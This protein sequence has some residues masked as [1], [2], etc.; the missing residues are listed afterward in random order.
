MAK[1]PHILIAGMLTSL[2]V[3]L[4][5]APSSALPAGS[6]SSLGNHNRKTVLDAQSV[7][8]SEHLSG[9][10]SSKSTN[11][12]SG[13]ESLI[14]NE[15]NVL[16]D[17]QSYDAKKKI[18][19]AQGNV[20]LKINSALLNADRVEFNTKLRRIY[21][22]GNVRFKSG[23]QYF[24]A[25][26]FRYN[27]D[28]KIGQLSDVYGVV[29]VDSINKDLKILSKTTKIKLNNQPVS[30]SGGYFVRKDSN[31]SLLNK[32]S[33]SSEF[34][35]R[36]TTSTDS[37]NLFRPNLR[38]KL[39]KIACPPELPPLIPR[40]TKPWSITTWGGVMTDSP[41]GESVYLKSKVRDEYLFGLGINKRIYKTGPL[42]FE[43]E[44]DLLSH[45]AQKQPGGKHQKVRFA[46]TG[47]QSF[48]ELIIG[49]GTRVW[50]KPWLNIAFIEGLSFNSSMSNW[51]KTN[52]KNHS[53]LLNYL[54]FE[55]E[56]LVSE[57]LSLVGRIHHRSGAFGTF[58][59]VK[60]GSNA[61]LVGFKYRFGLNKKN[62]YSLK[63]NPPLDCNYPSGN[64]RKWPTTFD[65]SLEILSLSS[66]EKDYSS[67]GENKYLE[68]ISQTKLSVLSISE[69]IKLRK[70]LISKLDQRINSI[71]YID[72]FLI[73]GQ[74]GL[75][76][77]FRNIDEKTNRSSIK[78][79]QLEGLRRAKLIT[80]SIKN[81]RIQASRIDI[82]KN[83]WKSNRV[84]F[85]NDPLTPAQARIES[86]GVIAQRQDNGDTFIST[87][88]SYLI[89]DE[90]LKIPIIKSRTISKNAEIKNRW[91]F[92]IDLDDR[93]GLFIG[94]D[95]KK[96]DLGGKF[97]LRLQPQLLIQRAINGKTNSYI[98]SGS[99]I[100]SAKVSDSIDP[101]DIFGLKASLNGE[102]YNWDLDL[103]ANISTFNFDRLA[104]GSRYSGS[105]NNRFSVP[106]LNEIS[107]TLFGAYRYKKWNGSLGET[108][109]YTS[110]GAF[111]EKK[112][113]LSF[114]N[115]ENNYVMR[116]GFADYQAEKLN[117]NNLISLWR[118]DFLY[119]INSEYVIWR[120]KMPDFFEKEKYNY[121][122][123]PIIPGV[124]LNTKV[125]AAYYF[126]ED[127]NSQNTYSIS[128][129]PTITFG[130]FIKPF[131]DYTKLSIALGR[132]FKYGESPFKFD[133][134]I[135]LYT[136]GVGLTQQI[137]GPLLF[138]GG[139]EF[140]IDRGS[141][142]YGKLINSKIE[143]KWQ[144]RAYDFGIY[145]NPYKG[146][147]GLN[148]TL[149]DFEF[150]G[151]GLPFI[152]YQ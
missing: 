120:Q 2:G 84:S 133:E 82:S 87:K 12:P 103:D 108:N 17:I 35:A 36:T 50:F 141:E 97:K 130:E 67:N 25:S 118:G 71:N 80:G 121:S 45:S 142:H 129:G 140:N 54:G 106:F 23:N 40:E 100:T 73:Q 113:D 39:D 135:D 56:T 51:E 138:N 7:N 149:N 94:R 68:D 32:S 28:S 38:T 74:F 11:L 111:L 107:T 46:Q 64:S 125:T 42:S 126:Y 81:W 58:G 109:I 90:S 147:G 151:I 124:T 30:S 70:K 86:F 27:L 83:G 72:Q 29:R 78:L 79:N 4:S 69:Q 102:I 63:I 10:K 31:K 117:T 3:S 114:G 41:L 16:S 105:L 144:R 92:G 152:P 13:I 19:I 48:A 146:I 6:F 131:F 85:T 134:A 22:R 61:Y 127:A 136:F 24:Q 112:S 128:G 76:Y 14:K 5:T 65:D 44:A 18:F 132:T 148:F 37:K 99:S 116:L 21:A 77:N 101:S 66:S 49:I 88:S 8:S 75:P 115:I 91:V 137:Y 57:R 9:V 104:E 145:Y 53:Q 59:G 139:Y 122:P 62:N 47:D 98:E 20:S 15:L 43:L 93:D 33:D 95:I 60:A 110:Y 143:I 26:Y 1:S 96:I 52:R 34:L 123:S 55:I 119:S 89:L 150:T